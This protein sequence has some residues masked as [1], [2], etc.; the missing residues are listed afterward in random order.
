MSEWI[1][2]K[3]RL[4]TLEARHRPVGSLGVQVQIWPPFK[5]PGAADAHFAFYGKRVTNKPEFYLYGR[6][7]H[8]TH[9]M[10]LP[11]PPA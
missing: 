1:S 5:S 11:E 8:V 4:P 10:P 2:V 9:W 6:T 3:D 7:I